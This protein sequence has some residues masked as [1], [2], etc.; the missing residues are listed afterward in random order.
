MS[1]LFSWFSKPYYFNNRIL[2]KLITSFGFGLFVFI[3]LFLLEP[4]NMRTIKNNL[5]YYTL[6]YG[7]ITTLIL[8]IYLFFQ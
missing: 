1:P 6:G 5:F 3:F 2:Y 7:I 8:F 4:F